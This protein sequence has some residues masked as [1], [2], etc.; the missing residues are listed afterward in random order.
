LKEFWIEWECPACG[1]DNETENSEF[2][3]D[4][5]RDCAYEFQT[6]EEFVAAINEEAEWE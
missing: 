5:C 2:I 1:A 4:P 6:S 3:P